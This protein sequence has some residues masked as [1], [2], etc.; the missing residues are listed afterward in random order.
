MELIV[1]FVIAMI[2]AIVSIISILLTRYMD[3]NNQSKLNR[4]NPKILVKEG[5][6]LAVSR[7]DDSKIIYKKLNE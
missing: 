7:S 3:A 5:L 4:L 6:R 2:M 1:V